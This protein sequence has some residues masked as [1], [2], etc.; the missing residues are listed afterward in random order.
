MAASE[1]SLKL[2]H[3]VTKTRL[4]AIANQCFEY[5]NKFW[6]ALPESVY[7]AEKN[8]L[9]NNPSELKE[10]GVYIW[11]VAGKQNTGSRL[12]YIMEC[13]STSEYNTKHINLIRD[14]QGKNTNQPIDIYGAGE[15]IKTNGTIRING[16][17]GSYMVEQPKDIQDNILEYVKQMFDGMDVEIDTTY[18][19]FINEENLP[20]TPERL[21][22]I[23]DMG[24]IF[25]V[26]TSKN[27]CV[28]TVNLLKDNT[29]LIATYE[30]E[31]RVAKKLKTNIPPKPKLITG[32]TPFAILSKLTKGPNMS[33]IGEAGNPNKPSFFVVKKDMKTGSKRSGSK[34]SRSKQ[35]GSKRSRSK[36]SRSKRSRSKRSRSKQT[37][38]KRSRSK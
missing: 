13:L 20:L 1:D 27:S 14:I 28:N 24:V 17:S 5:N 11:L 34:R 6:Y 8:K 35:T 37:G 31:T 23:F 7:D 18:K 32:E 25:Y 30:Q 4:P 26:Y 29:R 12:L 38:S 3:T 15:L 16:L 33:I 10:D 36:R 2:M 19:T 9:Y 21:D 22:R